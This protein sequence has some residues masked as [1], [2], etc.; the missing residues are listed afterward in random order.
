MTD[1][2]LAPPTV[3]FTGF[4][5]FLGSALLREVLARD[6]GPV[7][8]L[9]QSE[10]RDLAERRA[11][12]IVTD[13]DVVGDVGETD[14]VDREE[15]I[16]LYEG[17]I[18]EPDLGLDT[19]RDA[20][21]GLDEIDDVDEIY[22]LAAVYD[23]DVDPDIAEAVNVRGT[24]HVLHVAEELDVSRFQYVSTCYVSGRYD[25]V[26]TADHLTEEQ[27]FNNH[28]EETKYRAEVAVQERMA[29]G[30][31]ATIYRPAITVGDSRTG[32]TDKFDGPY[33]LLRL[34]FAQP[35]RLSFVF[36]I[37][38]AHETEL[39][40]VPRDF[41]VDA[42]AE[43]SG[44][45]EAIGEVYQL[46]DP[47][48]LTVPAFIEALSDATGHRTVTVPAT[49]R[50]A[51]T[52]ARLLSNASVHVDPATIDYLDHPARY[53]CPN[54]TDALD[55]SGIEVPRFESYVEQLVA[56]ARRNPTV[57]DEPMA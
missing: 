16:R 25:G 39:N 26:F 13:L 34:L 50:L 33:N 17:D 46:C 1:S 15:R 47:D 57:G 20:D 42:I 5:G 52:A 48:P 51:K 44:R 3:L 45:S 36:S 6:D 40:V 2:G 23:L 55:G 49:K 37:P 10:Y 18:T 53:R 32:E 8:C 12:E 24:E 7:A 35:E 56:F 11:E 14:D 38:G 54:T 28:Y 27:S 22:H 43:L 30:L 41:V 9:I 29:D 31:P 4:P 19:T 21:D